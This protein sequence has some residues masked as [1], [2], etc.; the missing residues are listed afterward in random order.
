MSFHSNIHCD[1]A[2][3]AFE[4]QNAHGS[5]PLHSFGVCGLNMYESFLEGG[6]SIAM[7]KKGDRIYV[8]YM[9][10]ELTQFLFD[11]YADD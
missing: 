9:P 6:W 3:R 10:R 7:I 1:F 11:A 4:I 8:R 5:L 2:D